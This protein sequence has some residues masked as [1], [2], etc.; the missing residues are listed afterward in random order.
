MEFPAA[1]AFGL[2][3]NDPP[4]KPF[5]SVIAT[6]L[7]GNYPK[8]PFTPTG[9]EPYLSSREKSYHNFSSLTNLFSGS[10]SETFISLRTVLSWNSSHFLISQLAG[11]IRDFKFDYFSFE[12]FS[13]LTFCFY[14]LLSPSY[15]SAKYL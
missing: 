10:M 14:T 4:F 12:H 15:L 2:T 3:E 7:K 1:V 8:F 13:Y 6:T 9:I 11:I 5:S